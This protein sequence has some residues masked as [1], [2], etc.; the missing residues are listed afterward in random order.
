[1]IVV[2]WEEITTQ[3][4]ASVCPRGPKR[5]SP[6]LIE[7]GL[8]LFVDRDFSIGVLPETKEVLIGGLGFYGVAL[9]GV[10]PSHLQTGGC[11]DRITDHDSW[12]IQDLL[13]IRRRFCSVVQ[14]EMRQPA[15]VHRIHRTEAVVGRDGRYRQI[16]LGSNLQRFDCLCGIVPIE[17]E[18]RSQRRQIVELY[19][20]VF[21]EALLQIVYQ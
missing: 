19:R 5:R 21:R 2:G 4:K 16:V 14:G 13:E 18:L 1:M 8:S 17:R 12:V 7:L 15:R 10:G 9:H 20:R 3:S 6:K 11:A